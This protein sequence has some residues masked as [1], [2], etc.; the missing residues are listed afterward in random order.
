MAH[1]WFL[2]R[3]HH[4]IFDS[5]IAEGWKRDEQGT[6]ILNPYLYLPDFLAAFDQKDASGTLGILLAM[7]I[8]V[9]FPQTVR[10]FSVACPRCGNQAPLPSSWDP[11][12]CQKCG[13][14][15][16]QRWPQQ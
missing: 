8:L 13:L 12:R 10:S 2:E 1:M 7:V 14:S 5:R 15:T 16:N 9:A 6:L 3:G 11:A 4:R